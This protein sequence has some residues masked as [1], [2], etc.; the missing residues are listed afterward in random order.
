MDLN[1]TLSVGIEYLDKLNQMHSSR[2]DQ[3]KADFMDNLLRAKS[4]VFVLLNSVSEE[5]YTHMNNISLTPGPPGPIGPTGQQGPEGLMG[6]A[7][8]VGPQGDPGIQGE[9]GIA[10]DPGPEGRQGD[11]GQQGVSGPIGLPG[12]PGEPGAQGPSGIDGIT[13]RRHICK[14]FGC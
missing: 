13:V 1:E 12:P 2:L 11:V 10:G 7:G 3:C 5:I 14:G 9:Q 8:P 4:E 6:P